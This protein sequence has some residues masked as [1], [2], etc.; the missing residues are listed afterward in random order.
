MKK[1]LFETEN[2]YTVYDND[3]N[4]FLVRVTHHLPNNSCAYEV[5]SLDDTIVTGR[6]HDELLSFV[7][8]NK[9]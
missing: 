8:E 6:K 4:V 7:L 3:G 1:I 2:T 9:Q 5:E